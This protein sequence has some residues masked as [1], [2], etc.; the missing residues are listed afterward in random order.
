M[1]T[2]SFYNLPLHCVESVLVQ[3]VAQQCVDV[4][5]QNL[6]NAPH[7]DITLHKL[8]QKPALKLAS[9]NRL[10]RDVVKRPS[11]VPQVKNLVDQMLTTLLFTLTIPQLCF[12]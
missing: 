5:L 3:V 8:V 10:W 6:D 1:E 4:L 2:F 9:V 11:F 12:I 7:P